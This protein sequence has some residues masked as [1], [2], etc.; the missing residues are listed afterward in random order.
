M[1]QKGIETYTQRVNQEA[2]DEVA[3]INRAFL[4]FLSDDVVKAIGLGHYNQYYYERRKKKERTTFLDW[5]A[6][7]NELQADVRKVVEELY[8]LEFI[9]DVRDIYNLDKYYNG[10]YCFKTVAQ[11]IGETGSVVDTHHGDWPAPEMFFVNK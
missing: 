5:E 8:N 11:I 3:Y 7:D 9:K 10:K 1:G 2:N 4:Y 6:M